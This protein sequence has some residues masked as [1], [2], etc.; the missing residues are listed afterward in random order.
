MHLYNGRLLKNI[1]L[2]AFTIRLY[3]L[4]NMESCSLIRT[5][6]MRRSYTVKRHWDNVIH[7][8]ISS[9]LQSVVIFQSLL[10]VK[11]RVLNHVVRC[12]A[13]RLRMVDYHIWKFGPSWQFSVSLLQ[14]CYI[15]RTNY[16]HTCRIPLCLSDFLF[17]LGAYRCGTLHR[18]F[19]TAYSSWLD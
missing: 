1:R 9:H 15:I 12:A 19:L 13:S 3:I 8:A 14:S 6:A 4:L 17:L 10:H 7:R 16:I 18:D 11:V 5:C 2:W